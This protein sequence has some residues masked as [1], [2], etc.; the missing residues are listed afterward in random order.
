MPVTS[1]AG[2]ERTTF[3]LLLTHVSYGGL[4]VSAA[5]VTLHAQL[6]GFVVAA[7]LTLLEHEGLITLDYDQ[8]LPQ[9]AALTPSGAGLL[10]GWDR[11]LGLGRTR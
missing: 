8:S 7:A 3:H 11:E 9:A 10:A 5:G 6:V 1:S 4:A 2:D